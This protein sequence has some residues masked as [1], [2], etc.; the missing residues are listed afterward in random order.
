MGNLSL[1]ELAARYGIKDIYGANI[2]YFSSEEGGVSDLRAVTDRICCYEMHLI[3]SGFADVDIA[4]HKH[5]LDHGSLLVLTPYQ[6]AKCRFSPHAVTEGL[7]IDRVFYD[8]ISSTDFSGDVEIPGIPSRFNTVYQLTESQTQ[9]LSGI[10]CQIQKAIHY[11]HLYKMEMIQSMVHIFK[12]FISELP[13]KDNVLTPDFRNKENIYK[14]FLHLS[15]RNFRKERQIQFYAD[16]IGITTTYLS[17]VVK[18]ISGTTVNDHLT[19]RVYHEACNL[20]KTTTKTMGEIA[21]E[22]GFKDQSAFTNF[23][24]L[25]AHCSPKSFRNDL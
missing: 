14:I 3:L 13:F 4:G 1:P 11:M 12:L 16:K 24:K 7:L 17:R 18:E 5:H 23:F 15:E 20:L 2:A 19:R 21:Y 22:L 10:F 25:H 8:S 9:E 6:P